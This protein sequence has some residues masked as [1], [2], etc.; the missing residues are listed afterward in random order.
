MTKA[1]SSD[2]S[3]EKP[4]RIG[5]LGQRNFVLFL[6]GYTISLAGNGFV[7]VAL[8]FA[9]FQ[10]G[11]GADGVGL[12]LAAKALP[13]VLLLL[14]AGVAADRWSRQFV[15]IG[16]DVVCGLSECILAGL[17]L[18]QHASFAALV[19]VSA[20]IGIGNAFFQPAYGGFVP[21][22]VK[23]EQ[24]EAANSFLSVGRSS[25]GIVGAALGGLLVGAAG[26][27]WAIAIDA[28]SFAVSAICLAMIRA[29]ANAPER[30]ENFIRQLA[31]G[32]NGFRSRS[33]LWLLV[34]QT[35]LWCLLV[36]GPIVT[37]GA[38]RFAH[39]P[40][41]ATI[42]GS[43]LGLMCAGEVVGGLLMIRMR[44]RYPLR[45]ALLVF[46]LF[47]PVPAVLAIPASLPV[48][49]GAFFLGGA[50]M[51]SFGVI[52]S[53][54][55]QRQIPAE[56]LS[57]VSAYDNFGSLCLLPLGFAAAGPLSQVI[58]IGGAL[59]L[60][61]SYCIISTLGSLMVPAVRNLQ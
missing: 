59:W 56:L 54:T 41:G 18:T 20:F 13:T 33:W 48:S 15:M 31:E 60:A 38:T 57:R 34:L 2:E 55:M 9:V 46:V 16:A 53:T 45:F 7:S 40:Q 39:V 43:L 27:G 19:V 61:T 36:L 8:A 51:A 49:L 6:F 24:L 25:G 10:L 44:P 52:W 35:A 37:L 11:G 5:V 23:A 1:L 22:L 47:A 42:W 28:G 58:G 21:H 26:P 32:W 3:A 17:L 29:P 4:R 50:S 12:V 30:Q 14:A